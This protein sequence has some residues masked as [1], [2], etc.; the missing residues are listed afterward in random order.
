MP[1][2]PLDL[3]IGDIVQMRKPH[4]C[5]GATWRVVRL[6]DEIGLRLPTTTRRLRITKLVT[7]HEEE[8]NGKKRGKGEK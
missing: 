6:G 4:P 1:A 3:R 7:V 5:G 8:G 2:P